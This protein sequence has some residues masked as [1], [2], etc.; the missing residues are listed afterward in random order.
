MHSLLRHH[1]SSGDGDRGNTVLVGNCA[2]TKTRLVSGAS[3]SLAHHTAGT[4]TNGNSRR[5]V[6]HSQL[7]SDCAQPTMH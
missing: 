2:Q 1:T 6:Q 3:F 5:W 7:A 4:T